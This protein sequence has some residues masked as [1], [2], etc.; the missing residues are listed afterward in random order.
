M[1]RVFLS[2]G[3]RVRVEIRSSVLGRRH[4][5]PFPS[6][7]R[8][9]LRPGIAYPGFHQHPLWGQR[10]GRYGVLRQGIPAAFRDATG[11]RHR[12]LPKGAVFVDGAQL[13]LEGP[14]E[15]LMPVLSQEDEELGP[16]DQS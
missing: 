1:P 5:S 16:L 15:Q 13:G 3:Q 10:A 8:E 9:S 14:V 2:I 7:P 12:R 6:I 4:T 11:G